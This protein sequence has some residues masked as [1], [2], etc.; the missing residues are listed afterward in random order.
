V[1]NRLTPDEALLLLV[2]R[3][4]AA[5]DLR[6]AFDEAVAF[7]FGDRE[8]DAAFGANWGAPVTEVYVEGARNSISRFVEHAYLGDV[9]ALDDVL[10]S[11]DRVEEPLDRGSR[12][13]PS[14]AEIETIEDD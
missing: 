3:R 4:R 5:D 12:S 9:E 11:F 1:T 8:D 6:R 7:V 10:E 14:P 2:L 13:R